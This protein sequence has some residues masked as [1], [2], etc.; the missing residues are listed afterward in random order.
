M[1]RA[2][3]LGAFLLLGCGPSEPAPAGSGSGA[4]GVAPRPSARSSAPSSAEA[5]AEEELSTRPVEILKLRLTSGVKAKDPVDTLEHA[6]PGE[7]VYA[8]L[9]VRNRT[10][11][12]RKVHVV[13]RIGGKERSAT[14]LEVSES[15]SWRTWAFVTLRADEKP[16]KLE[17][18]IS[19]D[20]GLPLG[21]AS[22]PIP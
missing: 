1:T 14:D 5:A 11:R 10:G 17:V 13:F 6:K 21:E 19:D 9:T 22:L 18:E 3:V 4:A 2:A 7:R 20:E 16:G 8:H 12:P 15:W